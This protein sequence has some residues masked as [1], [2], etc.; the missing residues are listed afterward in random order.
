MLRN[1]Q[2]KIVLIFLC[3]GLIAILALSYINYSNM[4]DIIDEIPNNLNEYKFVMIDY[5][6]HVKTATMYVITVF[7]CICILVRNICY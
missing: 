7:S 6:E 4:Q 2:I 3:L 5:Q 1:I